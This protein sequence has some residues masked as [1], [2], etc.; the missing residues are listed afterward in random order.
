MDGCSSPSGPFRKLQCKSRNSDV[1]DPNIHLYGCG[2]L[3]LLILYVY[4]C[5]ST[6]HGTCA[7]IVLFSLICN[8]IC[9]IVSFLC[10]RR[11]NSHKATSGIYFRLDH[12][13][14]ILHIWGSS[15]SVLR[16]EIND[17]RICNNI[18]SGVTLMGLLST[19]F[20]L[21]LP[22]VKTHRI[23]I[24]GGFGTTNF[25]GVFSVLM[26]TS[27]FSKVSV[28]YVIMVLVNCI[29]AWFFLGLSGAH[30]QDQ[31]TKHFMTSGH[32]LMHLCSL[33]ASLVHGL[34]LA[35]SVC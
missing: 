30:T 2:I 29:G 21:F 15:I 34:V 26:K 24:I 5:P 22:L 3:L 31:T 33:F 1:A 13:G 23:I 10:H 7:G 9:F 12:V 8:L 14:I 32:S 18:I 17:H 25:L 20:L 6:N 11:F 27:S 16:L 35:H 19:V 28:S 4:K